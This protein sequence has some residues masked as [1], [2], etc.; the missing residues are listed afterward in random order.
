MVLATALHSLYNGAENAIKRILLE[1]DQ[2][3]PSGVAS[4]AELL[5]QASSSNVHRQAVISESLHAALTPLM[6][7]RHCF[8][9]AYAFQFEWDKMAE[10]VENFEKVVQSL[11]KEL[12]DFLDALERGG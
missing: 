7:F 9:H 12:V 6:A 3:V 8:R 4:H 2:V 10:H 5:T 11:R 1:V